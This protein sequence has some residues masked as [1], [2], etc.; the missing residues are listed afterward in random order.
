MSTTKSIME[1]VRHLNMEASLRTFCGPH[2]AQEAVLIISEQY[3][4]I[5]KAMELV[6]FPLAVPGT[7]VYRAI[8][9][10][11]TAMGYLQNAVRD[12][13]IAMAQ[14]L[15]TA[16]LLDAWVRELLDLPEDSKYRREYTDREMAL[17]ILSFLFASQD[18]MSSGV[19][20]M[21]QFL[22]D[23]PDILAKVRAEQD[24]VRGGDVDKPV[25]L[26]MLDEMVYTKAFVKE[27]LRRMPPVTMV[28]F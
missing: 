11:K 16:C 1:P 18:A 10:R 9:S 26:E 8:Q 27:S 21:F 7:K 17:V 20:Y 19:T 28:C 25:T 13:K 14:G 15:P 22:A 3:W 4:S 24:T 23:H 6:N 2:I 12:S 5:T